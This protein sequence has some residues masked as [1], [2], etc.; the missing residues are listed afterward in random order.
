MVDNPSAVASDVLHSFRSYTTTLQTYGA[1]KACIAVAL[2][3]IALGC[4]RNINYDPNRMLRQ[5]QHDIKVE[6]CNDFAHKNV[7][8]G[9]CE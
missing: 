8:H 9:G 3:L 2:A 5:F 7:I 6:H 4:A 1:I